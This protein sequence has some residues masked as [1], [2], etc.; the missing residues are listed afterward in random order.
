MP[1]V[2]VTSS[3]DLPYGP[4]QPDYEYDKWRQEQLDDEDNERR[5]DRPV[6]FLAGLPT[7]APSRQEQP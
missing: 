4:G 1:S 7:R 5:A 6:G 3:D 2:V